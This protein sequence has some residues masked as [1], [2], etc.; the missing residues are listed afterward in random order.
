LCAAMFHLAEKLEL[1]PRHSNPCTDVRKNPENKRHLYLS[2]KG[3]EA[4]LDA[5]ELV[6]KRGPPQL[7][8]QRIFYLKTL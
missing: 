3:A 4:L 1:R 7:Q 5:G 6:P 2:R 8:T